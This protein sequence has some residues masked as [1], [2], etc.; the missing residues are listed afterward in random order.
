MR[1]TGEV[2]G[3]ASSFGHA[4]AKAEMAAGMTLPP[5]GRALLTVNDFDKGAVV[6]LARDLERLGWQ[7]AATGG[8][9]EWLRRVGLKVDAINKVSEGSPHILDALAAGEID[10]IVNTPLGRQAHSDG[11][12][13]R[14]AAVRRQI[15]LLTTL[16]AAAAAVGAIR[17]LQKK[18]LRV[19]S[20]QEHYRFGFGPDRP[21]ETLRG[22]EY[23][24]FQKGNRPLSE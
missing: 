22:T 10:L 21:P 2:M 9:A 20:L 19:R 13:L 7:L 11:E 17:A 18:E 4:F 12:Q 3:H 24:A 1:S 15:P 14:R 23:N 16:S 6:K 5:R 8:T